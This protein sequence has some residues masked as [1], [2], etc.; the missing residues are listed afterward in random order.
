MIVAIVVAMVAMGMQK[1]DVGHMLAVNL[2]GPLEKSLG[3][4]LVIVLSYS[5]SPKPIVPSLKANKPKPATLASSPSSM[6]FANHGT[7]KRR[8]T[9]TKLS[10]LRSTLSSQWLH[11]TLQDHSWRPL[12]SDP[13]PSS[14]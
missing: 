12:R 2:D 14:P 6:N 7:S 5:S 11:I 8:C 1:P 13:R 3:S 4:V 10:Q 9:S